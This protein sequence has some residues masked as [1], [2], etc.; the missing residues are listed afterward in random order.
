MEEQRSSDSVSESITRIDEKIKFNYKKQSEL[1]KKNEYIQK[2][3]SN[4]EAQTKVLEKYIEEIENL[5][6][7]MHN[8]DLRL[9]SMEVVQDGANERWKT[10]INFLFQTLWAVLTSYLLVKIGLTEGLGIL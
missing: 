10:T 4:L 1:E 2:S 8:L 7:I 6:K 9:K 5:K 3:I